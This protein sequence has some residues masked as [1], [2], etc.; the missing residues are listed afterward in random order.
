MFKLWAHLCPSA[1]TGDVFCLASVCKLHGNVL[2][3]LCYMGQCVPHTLISSAEINFLS[4]LRLNSVCYGMPFSTSWMPVFIFLLLSAHWACL[5]GLIFEGICY[6][7]M[8]QSF[9]CLAGF[10]CYLP[11]EGCFMMCMYW[12]CYL[13]ASHLSGHWIAAVT[14]LLSLWGCGSQGEEQALSTAFSAISMSLGKRSLM[15]LGQYHLFGQGARQRQHQTRWLLFALVWKWDR[16]MVWALSAVSTLSPQDAGDLELGAIMSPLLVIRRENTNHDVGELLSWQLSREHMRTWALGRATD[17]NKSWSV[18]SNRHG[19]INDGRRWCHWCH[20]ICCSW[21]LVY[22][23]VLLLPGLHLP[24]VRSLALQDTSG[25]LTDSRLVTWRSFRLST[26]LWLD[27]TSL[28]LAD[29]A[30]LDVLCFDMDDFDRTFSEGWCE[31]FG[32]LLRRAPKFPMVLWTLDSTL[33]SE[34][35]FLLCLCLIL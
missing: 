6:S 5:I 30:I 20:F 15:L 17:L 8:C 10:K 19:T 7:T 22:Y 29:S 27:D 35:A 12:L 1:H 26:S 3:S 9:T 33:S 23:R 4:L 11:C 14:A 13:C 16:Q 2:H 24:P 18:C 31:Q 28:L 21:L 34:T 25:Y 32:L